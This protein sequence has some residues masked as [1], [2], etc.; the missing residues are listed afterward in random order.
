MVTLDT[1]CEYCGAAEWEVLPESDELQCPTCYSRMCP[2][3]GLFAESEHA[4]DLWSRARVP[5]DIDGA[6][7]DPDITMARAVRGCHICGKEM[8]YRSIH[9]Y[10]CIDQSCIGYRG[11]HCPAAVSCA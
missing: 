7:V 1:P 6:E 8:V 3:C 9:H 5:T 4:G 2:E 11:T 10:E